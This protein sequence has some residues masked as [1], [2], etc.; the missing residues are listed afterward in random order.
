[1][2]ARAMRTTP[3]VC[4][5]LGPERAAAFDPAPASGA[6]DARADRTHLS[7]AGQDVFGRVVAEELKKV[8]PSLAARIKE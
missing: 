3:A 8:M 4:D 1:M 5:E 6:R 2:A 7:P